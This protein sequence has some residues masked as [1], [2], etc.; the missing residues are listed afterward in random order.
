MYAGR[1]VEQ[2]P[3]ATRSSRRRSTRTPRACSARCRARPGDER[4]AALRSRAAAEPAQPAAGLPLRAALPYAVEKCKRRRS[5]LS[6]ARAIGEHRVPL[7]EELG[8]RGGARERARPTSAGRRGEERSERTRE[9]TTPLRRGRATSSSTSR[10]RRGC[11]ARRSARCSG[12][13][14]Q[15]RRRRG[16]D[17]RPRRR[18]GLRQVDDSAAAILRLLEPTGGHDRLRRPRHHALGAREL[19]PLRREMQMI[20]QDPYASLNPRMTV[21]DIVGEP[22]ASTAR[23]GARAA[24]RA[25]RSC[26]R[27]SASTP[28]TATATRT[29]SPAASASASASRARS[30]STRS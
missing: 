9:A 16:R 6:R 22:L 29:S 12:R 30:R 8:R 11:F 18:V 27:R 5:P 24:K 1:V 19:R 4:A 17:A 26:S 23:R 10:S 2:A 28:S 25:C 20:F 14:R 15:L 21:G 13:R 7:A 3:V